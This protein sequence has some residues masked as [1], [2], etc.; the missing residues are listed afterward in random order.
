MTGYHHMCYVLLD[1]MICLHFVLVVPP[2]WTVA[3]VNTYMH[4]LLTLTVLV[5]TIDALGHFE[6]G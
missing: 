6:T 2:A 4:S 5:T 1:T 3:A